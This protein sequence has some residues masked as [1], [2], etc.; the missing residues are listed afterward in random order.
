MEN[1]GCSTPNK[2]SGV[3]PNPLMLSG[4]AVSVC[5]GTSGAGFAANA[6]KSARIPLMLSRMPSSVALLC[7]WFCRAPSSPSVA[8]VVSMPL[9]TDWMVLS[10]VWNSAACCAVCCAV[11]SAARSSLS[12]TWYFFWYSATTALNSSLERLLS[13]NFCLRCR[14]SRTEVSFSLKFINN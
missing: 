10:V 13:S 7:G 8:A 6:L 4:D 5:T 9:R 1:K 12:V 3:L 11:C 14:N 2:Y